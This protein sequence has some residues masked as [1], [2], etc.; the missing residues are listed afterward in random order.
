MAVDRR[1][2]RPANRGRRG[3]VAVGAGLLTLVLGGCSGLGRTSV[4]PVFYDTEKKD[5]VLVNSPPVKGCHRF[6]SPGAVALTNDT[7][8]DLLAYPTDDCSG[9]S[10]YVAT[11]TSDVVAPGAG[12]WKSYSFIH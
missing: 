2:P 3:A 6:G 1:R 9:G 7:L 11:M 10:I 8:V 12:P 4:G 5:H